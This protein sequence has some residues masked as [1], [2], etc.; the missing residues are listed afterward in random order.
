M[1]YTEKQKVAA[2][3]AEHHPE[4]LFKRNR[5]ML[6]MTHEELHDFASGPIKKSVHG[7]GT[8][9][10]AEMKQGHRKLGDCGD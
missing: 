6:K 1:P 8:F 7:S 3:I 2:A 4:K 10:E 5:G 9:T